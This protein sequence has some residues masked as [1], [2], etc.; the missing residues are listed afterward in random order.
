MY[1]YLYIYFK[2]LTEHGYCI[3]VKVTN[4]VLVLTNALSCLYYIYIYIYNIHTFITID[5]FHF[6]FLLLFIRLYSYTLL[7]FTRYSKNIFYI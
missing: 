3:I 6:F 7:K 2:I 1:L 5:L 4:D